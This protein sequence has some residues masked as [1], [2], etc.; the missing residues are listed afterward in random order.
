MLD[1]TTSCRL[2]R[3]APHDTYHHTIRF[4]SRPTL[5]L[6]CAQH[7]AD[8]VFTVSPI[9][10]AYKGRCL[11]QAARYGDRTLSA[12]QIIHHSRQR[13]VSYAETE[14]PATAAAHGVVADVP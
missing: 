12:T 7:I 13:W 4:S 1:N 14:V 8:I 6:P 2:F 5:H 9:I 3:E 11:C 10:R